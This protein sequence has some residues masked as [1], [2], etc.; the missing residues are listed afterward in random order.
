[1]SGRP[2]VRSGR[3]PL[4]PSHSSL[5]TLVQRVLTVCS[6]GLCSFKSD[7][8]NPHRDVTRI[9]VPVAPS[10]K[11]MRA[12]LYTMVSVETS[13]QCSLHRTGDDAGIVADI[14]TPPREQYV[15]CTMEASAPCPFQSASDAIAQPGYLFLSSASAATDRTRLWYISNHL[16]SASFVGN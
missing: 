1:M 7:P 9:G 5:G 10:S 13:W 4:L 6:V 3:C 11:T 12:L 2:K 16:F 8:R 14:A 15:D